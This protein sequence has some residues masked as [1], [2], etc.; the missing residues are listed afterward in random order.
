MAAIISNHIAWDIAFDVFFIIDIYFQYYKFPYL[1][2]GDTIY[3]PDKIK[4]NYS[5]SWLKVEVL[6]SIPFEIC[7]VFFGPTSWSAWRINH[8][9]RMG[10]VGNY[11]QTVGVYISRLGVRI[12]TPTAICMKMAVMYLLINHWYACIW[13]IIHRY[14]LRNSST[15]WAIADGLSTYDE[16][17]GQHD[18]LSVEP[19]VAYN[20]A[21][22]F[23]ITS[24]SSVGYGDI[25]PQTNIET[26][27]EDWVCLTGAS[28][29]GAVI[30]SI[31]TYLASIDQGG[32]NA[33][34]MKMQTL[35]AYM[36]NRGF[37]AGLQ[38]AVHLHHQRLWVKN[39]TLDEKGIMQ[40]LPVPLR[41]EVCLEVHKAALHAVPILAACSAQTKRRVAVAFRQQVCSPQMRI[42]DAGDIGWD[43]YFIASGLV[44]V[45]LPTDLTVLDSAGRA[46]F[47][48][49]KRK[50]QALGTLLRRGNHFGESC[51]TSH[52]GVRQEKVEASILTELLLI[53]KASLEDILSYLPAHQRQ[54]MI[55]AL[56]TR[57][58][59]VLHTASAH[60]YDTKAMNDTLQQNDSDPTKKKDGGNSTSFKTFK[61]QKYDYRR[62]RV[63]E[64]RDLMQ[65]IRVFASAPA[66][67]AVHKPVELANPAKLRPAKLDKDE[68]FNWG[69]GGNQ[70]KK[71]VGVKLTVIHR[72]LEWHRELEPLDLGKIN[73]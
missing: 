67:A 71:R 16:S 73:I 23:V 46:L 8:L 24:L 31:S 51:L 36:A 3:D 63:A 35:K 38:E 70:S 39:S 15:S 21:F 45:R 50:A 65:T 49:A 69:T 26:L 56:I 55:N 32:E 20:R 64:N 5:K 33:F 1:D 57:N 52:S 29:F 62:K 44:K 68:S 59:N 37:P 11:V 72:R 34:K 40:D 22:F 30:G 47:N 6:A 54:E 42:Y 7:A 17:T 66:H 14:A 4:E 12:G 19:F 25:G 2:N 41:M 53:S 48:M 28:I 58:G 18:I 10:R 61:L 43:M 9:L 27:W 60:Q 13:F